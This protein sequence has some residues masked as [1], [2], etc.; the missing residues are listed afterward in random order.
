MAD[1]RRVEFGD[2]LRSRRERLTPKAVGIASGRRRRT[3]GL[4]R[5]EVAELAG[6]GVDW[7][8]RLEQGRTVSPSMTTIDALARA[9]RLSRAEHA[10]L[11]A[12]ARDADRRAFTIETVPEQIRRLIDGL[13]QPAYV[14]GRRWDLLVWNAAAEEVFGFGRLAE[15]D[16]NVLLCMFVNPATRALFGEGWA[17]EAKRMVAQFRATHD[18]WAGDPAFIALLDRL[19]QGSPE[20]SRW[21]GAHEVRSTASGRKV[22]HHPKKGALH[23]EYA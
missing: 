22:L 10:H 7:Y 8:V 6:I 12:L 2:F 20:F 15:A 9:L 23:F 4:R 1:P 14:T 5:E 19:R 17:E 21:W 3:A 18:V 11:R 16:R 13:N